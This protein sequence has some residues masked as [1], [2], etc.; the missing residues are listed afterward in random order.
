MVPPLAVRRLVLA[1]L[2]PL[3][4]LLVITSTP[5]AALAAV[6]ASRWLP[7]RWRPLRLLW[8][9]LLY[10]AVESVTLI[11]LFGLWIAS[12]FGR[13][14]GSDR[15]Q[16]AHYALMRWYL[17]ILVSSAQRRFH[18]RGNFDLDEA[19]SA[20]EVRRPLLVLARHA[21]PGDSFLLVHGLLQ[22]GYRP[23]IVLRGDLRWVPT[24]DVA[25]HRVPSFFVLR[26]Q[27]A[28]TG[29]Q[30]IASLAGTMSSGDALV[31]FP[32]GRNFT[33]DRR[34]HSISKLEELGD[35]DAAEEARE[36]R[37]VLM[38]RPGG[39]L[40]ALEAAPD[41]DVMFVAHAGLEE[42]S[43]IVD[44]WRGLPMDAAVEVKLWLVPS[45]QIPRRR[46]AQVAWLSWWWRRIDAWLVECVGE[47]ALPDAVVAEV[48]GMDL[49][50]GEEGAGD[51]S[52]GGVDDRVSGGG[53]G[54]GDVSDGGVG[55]DVS[56]GGVDDGVSGGS[57]GDDDVS[58]GGVV[59]R[60]GF[61][62]E[63][64]TGGSG[65]TVAIDEDAPD[66]AGHEGSGAPEGDRRRG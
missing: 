58:D 23:R 38:P 62:G 57:V 52:G 44:L 36:L 53:V 39:T 2:V 10:L 17:A 25:L 60:G 12:G 22:L 45:G 21:G 47:E 8:F 54:D 37:H 11:A 49:L 51:V 15:W 61:R 46:E 24:I 29:T 40:A 27:P 41:S 16:A 7:G 50:D 30:A 56:D 64:G 43:G 48:E 1:P 55:D 42:L 63:A 3:L 5:L 59:Y 9:L 26:G 32:E 19:R 28:G 14:V 66:E 18:L 31:I 4:T 34:T 13:R 20:D 65:E 35:H 33:P 6:F